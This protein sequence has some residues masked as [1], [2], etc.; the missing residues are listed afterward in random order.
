[1]QGLRAQTTPPED[2]GGASAQ[3]APSAAS[4]PLYQFIARDN[5]LLYV[6]FSGLDAHAASWKKTAAYRMLTETPLGTM[7]EA[8]AT[9][10]LDKLLSFSPNHKL[11]GT[12]VVTLAKHV[13]HSG[14][15][16]ALHARPGAPDSAAE[17][18]AATLV[19]RGASSKELRPVSSRLLG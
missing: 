14:W 7:L 12:G 16:L 9:Q 4:R 2:G 10:L 6:E 17:P 18:L 19:F 5:L 1:P 8:V 13:A 3:K 15:V 11:T